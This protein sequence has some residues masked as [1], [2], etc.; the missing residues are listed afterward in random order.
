MCCPGIVL[1]YSISIMQI[2]NSHKK[3]KFLLRSIKQACLAETILRDDEHSDELIEDMEKTQYEFN[4]LTQVNF[5]DSVV[6]IYYD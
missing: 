3:N 1:N 5:N 6:S 2:P 4:T